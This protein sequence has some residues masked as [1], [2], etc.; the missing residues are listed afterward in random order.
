M[1]DETILITGGAGYIG[2]H[3]A[4]L[5]KQAG[6]RVLVLDNLAY[7]HAE[8]VKDVV[9]AEL[10]VGDIC[11]RALLNTIFSTHTVAG[12]I[13]FAA[14]TYVR[15]SV[16]KPALYYN[17]NVAGTLTL[18][19]AMVEA[20]V[21]RIVFSS[22]CAIY[23]TPQQMPMAEDHPQAP[24][25]PYGMTKLMGEKILAD[26]DQAYGLRSVCFRYFNAAGA[27]PEARLGEDRTPETHLIPLM[28][29]TAL[30]HRDKIYIYG[31]DYDTPDGTCIR[32][33]IHVLDL[34]QAH[35]LGLE[36][37]LNNGLTDTFNL[38]TGHGFSVREVIEV[39]KQV[40]QRSFP[41]IET[42]RRAGDPPILVA[43]TT[44]VNK[45]LGWKAQRTQLETMLEDSWR[46][47]QQRHGR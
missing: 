44:K 31:T 37:L 11:D 33:Y 19:N 5:L 7:G 40:T 15:E 27:D 3:T 21:K 26:F 17:N 29:M 14:H 18:L 42:K 46:W 13:H 28:M 12:V 16:I 30:G 23:G 6:Y 1:T 4:L 25:S 9:G 41:V 22:T 34:A 32:D 36:Y 45:I 10:I 35:R 43:D 39:G 47:H 8:F 24:M 2:S 38:G 20:N